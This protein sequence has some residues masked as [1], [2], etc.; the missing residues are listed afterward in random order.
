MRRIALIVF[1]LLAVETAEGQTASRLQ[2]EIDRRSKELEQKVVAWRRD[3]HQNPEL[4]NREFRTSKIV[5]EHL[6]KLGL[7]VKTG[8]AHTGVVGILRGGRPGPVVALRADMDAL[9]VTEEVDLPFKSTAKSQYNGQEVGVMHACGHDNHVAILM[10]VAEM[11]TAMKAEIPGTVKF[12]FQPAEEN[13]PPG[14]EGGAPLMLK[15]GVFENPKVD[16]IF[17]LHVFP[18]EVGHVEYRPAGMMASS[19]NFY[20]T[21]RG[22]QTHGALPW[23]GVDPI[24]AASQIVLGIQTLISRQTD[25]TLTPAVVTV[26]M[27]RGG[28]RTNIVPDSVEMAGTIRTFDEGVRAQLHERLT[29]TAESIAAASGASASV[30][31]QKMAPVTYNDPALTGRMIPT[32][33]R[34]LGKDLVKLGQPTTTAEDFA[35]YQQVVPG[36]FFFIGV[37]PKDR[38]GQAAPNH[39]PRFYADEGVLV[40]GMRALANLAVDFLAAPRP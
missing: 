18:M 27:I 1:S 7:E 6:Q 38:L 34:V 35:F 24:V 17:G 12:I 31:I 37:T 14:E 20:I 22:R 15:E 36:M 16:A 13:P 25:L 2:S 8:V 4:S 32:L 11:L 10:G 19:D 39:S 21:V 5:A 33:E 28:I 30:R 9:P 23:N 26:G 40:P 29:R 3:F